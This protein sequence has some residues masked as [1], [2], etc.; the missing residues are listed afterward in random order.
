MKCAVIYFSQTGNTEQI[1]RAVHAGVKAAAGHADLLRIKD[2]HPRRLQAYDL[3]GIGSPVFGYREAPNVAA[4]IEEMR[5]VG[6]KHVFAFA[7]HGTHG[8]YFAPSI[9]P[10]LR[11]RGLVVLG[12]RHWYGNTYIPGAPDPYPTAGHPDEID[13]REAEAFGREMAE[14]SRRLSAGEAVTIPPLPEPP[15]VGLETMLSNL[16]RIEKERGAEFIHTQSSRYDKTK[17]LYPQCHLCMDNCPVDGIDLTVDPPVIGQPC[18]HCMFCSKICPTGAM[19]HLFF[20]DTP[21]E[22]TWKVVPEFHLDQLARDEAAGR[23]RRL[24]PV[25]KIGLKT[26]YYVNHH[27]RPWWI[28]GKGLQ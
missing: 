2:A 9:I 6:G 21:A 27:Q 26:P 7:T 1:A 10:K 23:F 25:D 28:I 4:F 5:F 11:G 18:M 20:S 13:R 24:V 16:H 22:K 17:C 3:L 8:E 12:V 15:A 19:D 14:L